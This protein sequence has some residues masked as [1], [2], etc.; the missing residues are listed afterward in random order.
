MLLKS[1][2]FKAFVQKSLTN[3]LFRPIT[4]YFTEY[5]LAGATIGIKALLINFSGLFFVQQKNRKKKGAQFGQRQND[6]NTIPTY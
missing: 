6:E 5:I 3:I 2:D 1:D 4:S